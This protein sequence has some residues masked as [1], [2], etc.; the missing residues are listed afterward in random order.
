VESV[1]LITCEGTF[2]KAAEE[3]NKRRVV[4]AERVYS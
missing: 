1:T 2:S 3:Y 4:R